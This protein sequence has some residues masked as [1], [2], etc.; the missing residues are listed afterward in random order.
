M[1]RHN[2]SMTTLQSKSILEFVNSMEI[3]LPTLKTDVEKACVK[4]I[5]ETPKN[6][7]KE[8]EK[9][10][11][12]AFMLSACMKKAYQEKKISLSDFVA[13]FASHKRAMATD[14]NDFGAFGDLYELLV[15]IALIG[16]MQLV[17]AGALSVGKFGKDDVISKKYGIIEI[18]HNGKT[19]TSATVFD[20]MA[21]NYQTVIY[22]MFSDFDKKYIFELCEN[23]NVKKALIEIKKR[24]AIWTDKYQFQYDINHLGKNGKEIQ[25]LTIKSGN[26][27]LQF[28][29][30]MYFNFLTN[31]ENGMY[32]TL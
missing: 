14:S 16:K 25:A 15:R 6:V 26:V 30:G 29:P 3:N 4:L 12:I 27:Q 23:G 31:I 24:T 10:V 11:Y 2:Y 20:Y 17:H 18:G 32:E 21:G 13:S 22:G 8:E 7:F 19:F 28:T 1:A 5:K 9:A